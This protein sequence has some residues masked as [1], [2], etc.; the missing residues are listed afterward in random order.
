MAGI[1]VLIYRN[2]SERLL[3]QANQTQRVQSLGLEDEEDPANRIYQHLVGIGQ[4]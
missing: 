2:G 4:I 3:G 1:I